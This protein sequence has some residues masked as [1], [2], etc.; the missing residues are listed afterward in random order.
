MR[1]SLSKDGVQNALQRATI[2]TQKPHYT[3]I[4]CSHKIDLV[5]I[6]NETKGNLS[7]YIYAAVFTVARLLLLLV[8]KKKKK[9]LLAHPLQDQNKTLELLLSFFSSFFSHKLLQEA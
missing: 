6:Q 3:L 5:R 4:S 9:P 1:T 7:L 8:F 2:E